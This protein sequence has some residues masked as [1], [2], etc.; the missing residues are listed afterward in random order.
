[1][2]VCNYYNRAMTGTNYQDINVYISDGRLQPL[3]DLVVT[4]KIYI[5]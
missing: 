4:P 1:M 3:V 2:Y 5:T